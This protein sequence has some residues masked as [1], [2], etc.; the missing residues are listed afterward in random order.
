MFSSPLDE[1]TCNFMSHIAL[2]MINEKIVSGKYTEQYL[3]CLYTMD[4]MTIYGYCTSSKIKFI[5]LLQSNE[6]SLIKDAEIKH[7]FSKIHKAYIHESCNPFFDPHH[8][9]S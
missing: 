3:G 2:D 5:L 1:L 4:D 6:N 8:M 7:L 9:N